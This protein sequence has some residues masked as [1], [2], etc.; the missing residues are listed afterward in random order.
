MA[1]QAEKNVDTLEDT[2]IAMRNVAGGILEPYVEEVYDTIGA[3]GEQMEQLEKFSDAREELFFGQKSNWSGAIYRKVIQGGVESLLHRVDI[4]VT[5][6]F[7]GLT[8]DEAV[9][10]IGNR[11]V[12]QLRLSGVPVSGYST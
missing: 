4:M 10:E 2:A 12:G 1:E 8:M 5:N 7:H 9:D 6:N 11:I 3:V